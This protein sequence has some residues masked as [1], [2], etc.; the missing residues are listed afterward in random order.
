[1]EFLKV[2]DLTAEQ[3]IGHLIEVRPYR[4][5][6]DRAFVHEMLKKKSVST[7]LFH[8][9]YLKNMD[10]FDREVKSIQEDAGY[11]VSIGV[12]MEKGFPTSPYKIPSAM[13]LA[14][15]NDEELAYQ[16]GAVTAI[17]ARKHGITS[18]GVIVD[19]LSEFSRI[20]VGRRLGSDPEFVGRMAA[21]IMRGYRDHGLPT[22]ASIWPC[23]YDIS[24]DGHMF[25]NYSQLT[26]KDLVERVFAPYRYLMKEGLLSS[27]ETSHNTFLKIDPDHPGVLS[28]KILSIPRKEGFDGVMI[29]DSL[30]MMSL[31][32]KFGEEE[33]YGLAIKAGNDLVCPDGRLPWRQTYEWMLKAYRNGVFSEERL[34]QAVSRIFAKQRE[35]VRLAEAAKSSEVSEYQ[36]EC[37]AKIQKESI[38][39]IK[40][41][42]VAPALSPD[43]KKLFVVMVENPYHSGGDPGEISDN[44]SIDYKRYTEIEQMLTDQFP[45]CTVRLLNQLPQGKQV[46]DICDLSARLDE[47][48]YITFAAS[49]CYTGGEWFTEQFL[50]VM[51]C[52]QEKITAV[53]HLGNPVPLEAA[54]H[55]PRVLI[56]VGGCRETGV[57]NALAILRGEY[58]PKGKLPIKLNLQ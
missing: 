1:M 40:D 17:E 37:F 28:E 42:T 15:T 46:S 31:R 8:D 21:A 19:L 5:E 53:V 10:A 27:I 29:S 38:C 33:S 35:A 44:N 13:A 45:N 4:D 50:N 48:V 2:E 56:S 57:D 51:R 41:E 49:R 34:N 43:S 6:E 14:I 7:F 32:L 11:P 58:V 18:G 20:N 3:K 22:G 12:N 52:M 9:K 23:A 25:K 36:K 54:P 47:T 24:R 26:E 39:L 55:I 30:G 16:F